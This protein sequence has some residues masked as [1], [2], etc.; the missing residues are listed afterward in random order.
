MLLLNGHLVPQT[1]CMSWAQ[2]L[3]RLLHVLPGTLPA[4]PLGLFEFPELFWSTVR[5]CLVPLEG[6]ERPGLASKSG[7]F[8]TFYPGPVTTVR[9]H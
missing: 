6:L 2:A 3:G 1:P 8:R 7:P 4:L 9:I 5:R